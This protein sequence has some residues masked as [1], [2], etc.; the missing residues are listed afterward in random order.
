M[1]DHKNLFLVYKCY[2][3]TFCKTKSITPC[4]TV[5]FIMAVCLHMD[6]GATMH[7][8]TSLVFSEPRLLFDFTSLFCTH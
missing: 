8:Q 5:F 7:T 4:D 1:N 3:D 6:V 2:H